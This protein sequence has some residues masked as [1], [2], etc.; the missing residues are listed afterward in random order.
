MKKRRTGTAVHHRRQLVEAFEA[1][2]KQGKE[3]SKGSE[4]GEKDSEEKSADCHRA[5]AESD[6]LKI[7]ARKTPPPR[8]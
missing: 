6:A 8:V 5:A 1:V 7:V 4:K 2:C 3:G